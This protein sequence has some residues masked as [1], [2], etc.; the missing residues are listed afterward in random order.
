MTVI[1]LCDRCGM[2]YPWAGVTL[3]DAV[4]CCEG[5]AAGTGCTCPHSTDTTV[6]AS[7]DTLVIVGDDEV[8]VTD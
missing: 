8:L 3:G 2:Q 4:Y 5:C 1:T 7:D 6:I